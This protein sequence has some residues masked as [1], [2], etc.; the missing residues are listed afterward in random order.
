LE[1]TGFGSAEVGIESLIENLSFFSSWAL[2]K[3]DVAVLISGGKDSALALYRAMKVGHKIK[4]LVTMIPQRPDSWMFHYP[5]IQ[6]TKLFAEAAG[7]PLVKADASGVKEKELNSLKALLGTLDVEAVVSGA[8]LSQYQKTRIDRV[9]EELGLISIAPLWQQDQ[10][11]LMAEIIELGFHVIITGV[12]AHGLDREWLGRLID[13]KVLDDLVELNRKY[14]ISI[15][16]EGGEYETLVLDAPYF[17]KRIQIL[18]ARIVWEGSSG[19]LLVEDAK[20]EAKAHT[21]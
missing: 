6:L 14:G 4:C 8:I 19:Y 10:F 20:L 16:G 2:A 21:Y 11:G 13:R 3:L 18:K 9:C 7:F 12:Y 15:V 5:N 1:S 17:N